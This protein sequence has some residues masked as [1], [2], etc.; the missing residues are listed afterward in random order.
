MVTDLWSNQNPR[1]LLQNR[2]CSPGPRAKHL[3]QSNEASRASTPGL[4][5]ATMVRLLRWPRSR[6][7]QPP[8][9]SGPQTRQDS[10]EVPSAKQLSSFLFDLF[11]EKVDSR[12]PRL[13]GTNDELASATAQ[14]H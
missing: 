10:S 8:T 13:R 6:S 5:C 7:P 2:I 4:P 1:N 12:S 9:P 3:G 14:S 11:Q